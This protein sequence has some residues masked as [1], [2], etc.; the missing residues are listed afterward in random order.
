[1]GL[2]IPTYQYRDIDSA[3][4]AERRLEWNEPILWPAY[5]LG[6]VAILV[7]IPGIR[8]YLRERQ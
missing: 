6:A 3:L 5:V 1:M 4:R 8:T 2:S 7:V